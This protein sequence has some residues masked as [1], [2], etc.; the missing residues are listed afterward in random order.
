MP[1][2]GL[3]TRFG[4]LPWG[5]THMK[6]IKNGLI[7]LA[8]LVGVSG[9]VRAQGNVPTTCE[10]KA[11]HVVGTQGTVVGTTVS[12]ISSTEEAANISFEVFSK[13]MLKP[14]ALGKSFEKDGCTEVLFISAETGKTVQRI[15]LKLSGS[16]VVVGKG[17]KLADSSIEKLEE[18]TAENLNE[19]LDR[20]I[21]FHRRE[22]SVLKELQTWYELD[23]RHP[24]AV[25][26]KKEYCANLD[27]DPHS[28]F[29]AVMGITPEDAAR[30]KKAWE[31]IEKSGSDAYKE[32]K[33][34]MKRDSDLIDKVVSA[35]HELTGMGFS[36]GQ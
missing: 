27:T 31:A 2:R 11:G 4:I 24:E 33:D 23:P 21:G 18:P 8:V 7:V 25:A 35:D 20:S 22:L 14:D 36:C 30:T 6:S 34:K 9:V 10:T 5:E 3:A 28:H 16:T 17:S 15:N 32:F 1:E 13:D 12:L 19:F 26:L 29:A